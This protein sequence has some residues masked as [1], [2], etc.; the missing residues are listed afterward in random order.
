MSEHLS[1]AL[2]DG[3]RDAADSATRRGEYRSTTWHNVSNPMVWVSTYAS[4]YQ[5]LRMISRTSHSSTPDWFR[6]LWQG[7]YR[8]HEQPRCARGSTASIFGGFD[9]RRRSSILIQSTVCVSATL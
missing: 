8:P 9:P 2:H 3:R 4:S 7:E 1:G 5:P 6:F